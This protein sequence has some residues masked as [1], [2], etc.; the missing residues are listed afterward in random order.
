MCSKSN[1]NFVT[2]N[3]MSCIRFVKCRL[4]VGNS[5]YY[6]FQILL[7]SQLIS[8]NLK[9]KTHKTIILPVVLQGC[10]T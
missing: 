9:I 10:E 8:T 5:C 7:S 1:G 6:S 4:K 3:S 2:C